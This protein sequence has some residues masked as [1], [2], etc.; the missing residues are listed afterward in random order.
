CLQ[1]ARGAFDEFILVD[2][3]SQDR[4]VA[5]AE[6]FGAKV[7]HRAWDDDFSAPRNLGLSA[8]TG[9]WVLV[10]DADEFILEGGCERIRELVQNP[11]ALGYHLRFT[12]IY[13]GGKTI[14]V[15]M[16]RLF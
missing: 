10:L 8:A 11:M 16:V 1:H 13:G 5:I 3:G 6:S 9:D 2:T 7:L 12:N 4:T 15:L 14:G